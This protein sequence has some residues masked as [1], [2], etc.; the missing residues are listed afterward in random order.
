MSIFN[1]PINMSKN[2]KN[3][4]KKIWKPNLQSDMKNKKS[5]FPLPC[6]VRSFSLFQ[7]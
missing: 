7:V 6:S 3:V 4:I 1:L 5:N 2:V